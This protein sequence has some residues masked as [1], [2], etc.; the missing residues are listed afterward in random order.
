MEFCVN[1]FS[2][3]NDEKVKRKP[4]AK[5]SILSNK[6]VLYYCGG[7]IEMSAIAN[8]T[9]ASKVMSMSEHRMYVCVSMYMLGI[10][11]LTMTTVM[12]TRTTAAQQSN[13]SPALRS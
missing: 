9:I 4:N 13:C 8:Q 12:A 10:I 3:E 6:S 1:N 11:I 5:M 2:V 7:S